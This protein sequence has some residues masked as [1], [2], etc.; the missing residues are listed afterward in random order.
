[1]EAKTVKIDPSQSVASLDGLLESLLHTVEVNLGRRKPK[2]ICIV[3]GDMNVWASR[4]EVDASVI[5]KYKGIPF[6]RLEAGSLLHD[7]SSFLLKVSDRFGVLVSMSESDL[8]MIAA[9]NLKGRLGALSEFYKLDKVVSEVEK[10]KGKLE[11]L[12]SEAARS[13][14][15][16]TQRG[17]LHLLVLCDSDGRVLAWWG[18]TH[19]RLLWELAALGAA[20]IQMGKAGEERLGAPFENATVMYRGYQLHA[21]KV[22]EAEG[23]LI[24]LLAVASSTANLGLLRV[25]LARHARH[26]EAAVRVEAKRTLKV[27]EEDV[28]KILEKFS[29]GGY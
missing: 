13:Y 25:K 6:D 28:E 15:L 8:S 27:T 9:A 1:M 14:Q 29:A 17:D 24:V 12:L 5:S 2:S 4:G 16:L 23:R 10:R 7:S 19:P 3:D 20:L 26:L 22:C 18:S 11:A 21:F